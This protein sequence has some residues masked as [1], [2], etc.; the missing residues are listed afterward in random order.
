MVQLIGYL[1]EDPI[2]KIT[3]N[4][5]KLTTMKLFT[6]IRKKKSDDLLQK[7]VSWHTVI[8]WDK[9]AENI[10]NNFME[11]SHVL[12]RGEVRNIQKCIRN[13]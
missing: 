2:N 13:Y 3:T 12:I 1:G 9:L 7:K 6:D 4:G 5:H 8:A 10:A 11:G